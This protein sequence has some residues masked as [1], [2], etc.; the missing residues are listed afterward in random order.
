MID[1]ICTRQTE[2]KLGKQL[3]MAHLQAKQMC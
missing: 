2:E 1:A 3:E